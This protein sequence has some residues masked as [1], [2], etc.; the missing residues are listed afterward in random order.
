MKTISLKDLPDI[1][2]PYVTRLPPEPSGYMH[3]GHAK[4]ALFNDYIAHHYK[5]GRKCNKLIVRF[6]DTNPSKEKQVFQDAILHDLHTLSI[7]P[8]EIS[9][10][11]DRFQEMYDYALDLIR[12]GKVLT[13]QPLVRATISGN[14]V[15]LRMDVI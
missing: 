7:L 13:T 6:D 4:A 11:S 5:P 10:S 15:N 9:H 14:R 1:D 8:D 3:I 12:A 2:G